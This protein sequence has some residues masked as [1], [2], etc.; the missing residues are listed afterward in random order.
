MKA[1][2]LIATLICLSAGQLFAQEFTYPRISYTAAK[3][4]NFI[5]DGWTVL[6]KAT[7]NLN[8]DNL[9]DEALVL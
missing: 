9:A 7:G 5:P 1:L 6:A 8:Q 3:I 2:A 4:T